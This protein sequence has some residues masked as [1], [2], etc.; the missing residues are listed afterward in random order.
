MPNI[1]L[2]DLRKN[3]CG[4]T[5]KKVIFDNKYLDS[6]ILKLQ[7]SPILSISENNPTTFQERIRSTFPVFEEAKQEEIEIFFGDI[8]GIQKK[9]KKFWK[10][11]TL[12]GDHGLILTEN[13]LALETKKH[14]RSSTFF[15]KFNSALD[16]LKEIYGNQ[17]PIIKERLGLRYINKIE[18][19]PEHLEAYFKSDLLG[20]LDH[21]SPFNNIE[22]TFQYLSFK[23]EDG[24]LSLRHGYNITNE[25]NTY[26]LDFDYFNEKI[27]ELS[28]QDIIEI[29]KEYNKCI[30]TLFRWSMREE[31]YNNLNPQIIEGEDW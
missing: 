30:Y 14:Q 25:V 13:F 18:V 8:E 10:F 23:Q 9:E 27:E 24:T 6:V 29:L 2:T 16:V 3:I 21:N 22:K 15:E 19:S 1:N 7:F 5:V 17:A 26:I 12:N 31:L 4:E 20:F 11:S 28:V